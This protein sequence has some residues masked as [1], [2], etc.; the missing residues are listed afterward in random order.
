MSDE[1]LHIAILLII[2]IT[3]QKTN[4]NDYSDW[5]K[6][7]DV[8]LDKWVEQTGLWRFPH[9]RGVVS[10]LCRILIGRDPHETGAQFFFDYIKSGRGLRS[11]G[12]ED[13]LGAQYQMIKQGT[14]AIATSMAD[15]LPKGTVL[16]K[17]PV[18]TI[19]HTHNSVFVTTSNGCTY[20]AKKAVLAIMPSQ[21]RNIKFKPELP[22][23]KKK[24]I[25]ASKPGVY[26]KMIVTY[27][28]PWWRPAGFV[29]KFESHI[30]P[31]CYSWEI[32]VPEFQQ[33]SLAFFVAGD[34]AKKW[35]NLPS[36]EAKEQSIVEHFAQLVG[37]EYA[38]RAR[39]TL[40]I[41]FVEWT[42]EE[43]LQGGPTDVFKPN[44]LR[45]YGDWLRKPHKD[46][47][48]AGTELA[49]EWKG[50]LEGA[51]TSGYRAADEIIAALGK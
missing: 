27:S 24:V 7:K 16:L 23:E 44:V 34:I 10:A 48:F 45:E 1:L 41:N 39:D 43:F 13:Y 17:S 31:I 19:A 46:L 36:K 11:L 49:Y 33:Y 26:V 42:K 5:P 37:P 9:V 14:S 35:L 15:A 20:S 12:T 40:E 51:V 30:G 6:D 8:N 22:H 4:I 29:G 47:H 50:Y 18:T 32:S 38:D 21:Y 2:E 28:E 3:A 25:S